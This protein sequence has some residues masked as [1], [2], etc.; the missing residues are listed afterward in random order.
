M[1]THPC[2]KPH[3]RIHG[4]DSIEPA[5]TEWVFQLI[6]GPFALFI[7]FAIKGHALLSSHGAA[8]DRHE[9]VHT[10]RLSLTIT[11]TVGTIL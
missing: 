4:V 1:S 6:R 8:L 2:T 9:L 11:V 3:G 10:A 5:H 7:A